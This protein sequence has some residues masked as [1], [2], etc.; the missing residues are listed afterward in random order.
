MTPA[1]DLNPEDA[2]VRLPAQIRQATTDLWLKSRDIEGFRL[3]LKVRESEIAYGIATAEEG[4]KKKYPNADA[5]EAP[6]Q[7]A[8]EGDAEVGRLRAL[9][10]QEE[11]VEVNIKASLEYYR[12]VQQNARIL[13]LARSPG[14]LIFDDPEVRG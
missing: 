3:K 2:L 4:G 14:A 5:R 6:F 9:L 10:V 1:A 7:R 8:L 13:L 11:R 12:A